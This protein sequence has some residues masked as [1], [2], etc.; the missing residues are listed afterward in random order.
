MSQTIR[1]AV[2]PA[3]GLGTRFLPASKVIPK[4]MLPIVDKPIIQYV[5][6]ELVE[7]GIEQIIIVTGWHKRTIEDHFDYPFELEYR[8]K[9]AGK[10]DLFEVQR[11]IADSAEFVYVRQREP[12]GTGHAIMRARDVVGNEPFLVHFGD[13]IIV[14]SV[15]AASQLMD[16][17]E[18]YGTPVLAGMRVAKEEVSK[19]GAIDGEQ[20]DDRLYRVS[21]LVEKPESNAV[22]TD[23]VQVTE[24]ILTPDWFDRMEH[25]KPSP[26]GEIWPTEAIREMARNGGVY[27]YEFEGKRYDCGTKLGYL[28]ANIDMGLQHCELA[29]PLKAHLRSIG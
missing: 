20:I 23:L 27:A 4:E 14:S 25:V 12:L 7:A 8:L 29:E 21:D 10:N 24:Y 5:V 15:P 22:R 9:Q 11:K 17:Y 26:G 19:Y 3:A 13:D 2:I 18:K 28:K 16:V 6:E 1:K